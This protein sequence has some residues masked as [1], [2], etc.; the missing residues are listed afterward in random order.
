MTIEIQLRNKLK[1]ISEILD[2]KTEKNKEIGV[3]SGVSG[4]ALFQFYYSKFLDEDIHADKGA[5][6]ITKA[7]EFI[8]DGFTY[9]TFCTG[10]AGACWVLEILKEEEFVEL[11]DDFLSSDLDSYLLEAMRADI[12]TGNYDFLHGAMGYGYY[13]L[14]RYQ[15]VTSEE[16]KTKYKDYL[17]ELIAELKK[18]SKKNDSGMWW[19][20]VLKQKEDITGCNLSLSH[21]ISSM[22]NFLS[23]IAEHKEFYDDVREMLEQ[24]VKYILHCRNKDKT[25]TATFPNWIINEDVVDNN[26]RLAWCYGDLGIGI[27]IYRA[28]KIL[29]DTQISDEAIAILKYSTQRRDIEE[30]GVL[31][32]G[33]CHGAYGILLIYNYLYKKTNDVAFKEASDFWAQK[34]LDMAIHEQGYAGYM[35]WRGAEEEKWKNEVSLLEG[36]AGIGLSIISYLAPFETKW[37]ECLLIS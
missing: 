18:S 26:S 13:F 17:D 5:E 8:N 23:R 33:L 35:V 9:P 28:G 1:E 29:G 11:D 37:D 30:A 20:S 16:S 19:E 7:V 32:A 24:T 25:L 15:N 27:S 36:V 6:T 14:K 34:A 4:V 31:D 3:L 2:A 12:K 22:V 10:I 21:G